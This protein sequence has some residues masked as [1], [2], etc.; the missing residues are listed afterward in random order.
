MP[1]ILQTALRL[2]L[3][4]GLVL[5]ATACGVKGPLEPPPGEQNEASPQDQS[6]KKPHR[7][8]ILDGPAVGCVSA[9]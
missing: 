8:Y 2:I 3:C 4:A 1:A 5:G 6:G 7:P 9:A